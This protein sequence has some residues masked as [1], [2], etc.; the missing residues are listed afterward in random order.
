MIDWEK[1]M[2]KVN[3]I[4]MIFFKLNGVKFYIV[5]LY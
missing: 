1:Y 2:I 3:L 5:N 4:E